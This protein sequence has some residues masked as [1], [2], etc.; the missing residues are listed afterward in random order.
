MHPG[1]DSLE[2]AQPAVRELQAEE[3][4]ENRGGKANEEEEAET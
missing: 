1:K 3:V 2:V 4:G